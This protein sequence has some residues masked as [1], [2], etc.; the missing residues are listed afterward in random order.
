MQQQGLV[1]AVEGADADMADA[2][3]QLARVTRCFH[4]G[5]VDARLRDPLQFRGAQE[6]FRAHF[7][8]MAMQMKMSARSRLLR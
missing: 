5:A 4:G 7:P 1:G 2:L 6:E 8:R 3:P